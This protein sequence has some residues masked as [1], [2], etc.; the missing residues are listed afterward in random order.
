MRELQTREVVIPEQPGVFSA[1]G[2]LMSDL[3]RDV[4]RTR[5]TRVDA[6]AAPALDETFAEMSGR[7]HDDLLDEGMAAADIRSERHA[8]MRYLGQEHTVKVA[9]PEG[10]LDADAV[11]LLLERF[12]QVHEQTYTFRLETPVE[13]VNFHVTAFGLVPAPA[14]ET[15]AAEGL[16]LAGARKG[17]REV[18]F[19]EA[20][21]LRAQ[22]YEREHLPVDEPLMGPAVIEEPTATI[23]V[24]PGQRAR[25][26]CFGLIHIEE[27]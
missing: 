23:L 16:T 10:A 1:W 24:F 27:D 18:Y 22:I 17:Q 21:P 20:Q 13:L 15:I 9:L 3:R 2:M 26:D 14:V 7:V 11:E 19:D 12:H 25:R 4:I 5:I 6:A 8:D